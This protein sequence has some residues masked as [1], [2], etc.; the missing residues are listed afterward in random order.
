MRVFRGVCMVLG[1][2]VGDFSPTLFSLCFRMF[3]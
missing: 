3:L 2:C 1:F